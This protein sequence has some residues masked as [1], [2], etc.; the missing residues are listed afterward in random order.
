[1]TED[2][3]RSAL[4]TVAGDI[5]TSGLP[6]LA[7]PDH[8]VGPSRMR[9]AGVG[10]RA[11]R[12]LVPLGAAAAVTAIVVAATII[13]GGSRAPRPESAA[14]RLWHGVPA[15][16]FAAT[17]NVVCRKV[18]LAVVIDT[19]SGATLATT[20]SPKGCL[21]FA[22]SA[23]ADDR[24]F[25]IACLDDLKGTARLFLARFDPAADRLSVT[26]LHVPQIQD[27]M[28]MAL[29]QDGASIATL[30][31]FVK[32][33]KEQPEVILR[34]YSIA[35]GTVRT[36]S[37]T[38]DVA[39]AGGMSWGPGPLLVFGDASALGQP[40][41]SIRLLNTNSPPGSLLGASR[42]VVPQS[43]TGGYYEAGGFAVSGN[44]AT[45]SVALGR[46]YRDGIESEFAEFSM[47]NG[48]ILRRWDPLV[49]YVESVWWSD[50]TGKTLVVVFPGHGSGFGIMNGERFTPLPKMPEG[51]ASIAF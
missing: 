38:G 2:E 23:A 15:D 31:Q 29:S 1:M 42:V 30:S 19:R 26:A 14:P 5:T 35:T 50:F 28:S 11:R 49:D 48:R 9:A 27:F 34:V 39:D 7:L 8:R 43:L 37:G 12:W 33:P 46:R 47:T 41:G 17:C 25:A 51:A 45:V 21:F 32:S 22:V 18:W 20:R 10:P 4:R 3:F 36:W 6:P 40:G 44:G 16:Y 24:T 13:A